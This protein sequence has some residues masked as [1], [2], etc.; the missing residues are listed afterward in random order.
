MRTNKL[1]LLAAVSICGWI[2]SG[3]QAQIYTNTVV[4]FH[5]TAGIAVIGDIDV[6]LFDSEK[7]VTVRN[8]LLYVESGA[9]QSM[10]L[11][12][13][14]PGFIVQGGGFQI[15]NPLDSSPFVTAYS[16]SSF[17]KITN[18]FGVG[19]LRSN[20]YGTI[21]MAKVAGDPNS[22]TSHF[23]FNLANN[24]SILDG[25]NGG[26]T[27]FGRVIGDTNVLNLFNPPRA[28]TNGVVDMSWFYTNQFG[29]TFR[30]LPVNY[31]GA[32]APRYIDLFTVQITS[33]NAPDVLPPVVS[34]T[35]PGSNARLTTNTVTATG[36]ASDNIGVQL[37]TYRLNSNTT[38]VATGTTN[39]SADLVLVPGPNTLEVE[40]IDAAGNHSTTVSRTITY[41]VPSTLT[42]QIVGNGTVTG[43]AD[44]QILEIGKSYK[45]TAK[46]AAGQLFDGWSGGVTSSAPALTFVM[47]SNLTL[48]ATF[49][50][51]PFGP[52]SGNYNGLF[53]ETNVQ[54]QSSGYFS[55]KLTG[56]GTYTGSLLMQGSRYS[57]SG[58]FNSQGKAMNTIA[59]A[60]LS[61][62]AVEWQ[63]DLTNGTDHITG[64]VSDGVWVSPLSGNRAVFNVTTNPCPF[65]GK[66]TMIIPGSTN[67]AVSPAGDG[68]GTVTVDGN[69]LISLK[70][71]LADGTKIAQK[72]VS[73]SKNGEWPFYVSLYRGKGSMLSWIAF[74][75]RAS[76]SLNGE[77]HWI[78]TSAAVTSLYPAGFTNLPM[79]QGSLY[80]VPVGARVLN[81]TDGLVVLSGGNLTQSW[82]NTVTL[83]ADNKVLNTSSNTL[84]LSIALTSGAFK[85][86]FVEPGTGRKVSFIGALQQKQNAGFG[87]F[88]GTTESGEVRFEAA[89]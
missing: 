56:L 76:D 84:T 67:G 7:P 85:G 82:T 45:A 20:T 52:L 26:F 71:A 83:G 74:T 66:Y 14:E 13:C 5:L 54:H 17:G 79:I 29:Q 12:R 72:K 87:Y 37:V 23:F 81:F 60:G 2:S 48:I 24:S 64:Q 25:Q 42:L 28:L 46:P 49:F 68:F 18:E 10:F 30:E 8:F 73:L 86:S 15:F 80:T 43:I 34:I 53:S 89:P 16:V 58:H 50:S 33:T 69:G 59:R 62:L 19:P 63:L 39:W 36:K 27:V 88:L 57:V 4:R 6:E 51:N 61:P 9:Y 38:M 11:H 47:Q 78:K 70:G 75:N 40:S 22:A 41:V 44:G 31:S 21:A 32:T 65:L 1:V 35:S 77:S 55:L 3:L